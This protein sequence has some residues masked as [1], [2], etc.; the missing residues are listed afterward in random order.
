MGQVV[1]LGVKGCWTGTVGEC[2]LVGE[3]GRVNVGAG[4]DVNVDIAR[5]RRCTEDS[6][7]AG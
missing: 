5:A 1:G 6:S 4:V 3:D 2:G 7:F